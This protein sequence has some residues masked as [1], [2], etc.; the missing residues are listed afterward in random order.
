MRSIL[1]VALGAALLLVPG[2]GQANE[3]RFIDELLA[4]PTVHWGHAA[5]LV[6]RA[7]GAFDETVTPGLAARK[8][9][10]AGWAPG[11]RGSEDTLDL[12]SYAFLLVQA[13]HIPTGLVGSWFPGPRYA[14]R[15]LVFRRAIPGTLDPD[16]PVNGEQAMRYLAAV[17][18][19][20]GVRP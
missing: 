16:S 1:L 4:Q 20:L 8:G 11:P 13:F 2:W 10:E 17:Q 7:S 6:G 15:E 19:S 5:W 14:L 9:S 18:D 12:Q 3:D